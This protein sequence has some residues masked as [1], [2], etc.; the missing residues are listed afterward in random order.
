MRDDYSKRT[1]RQYS[2]RTSQAVTRKEY[3]NKPKGKLL[4]VKQGYNPNSSSMGSI[5]F[6]LPVALLGI[7]AVFG[8]VS[9]I[10]MSWHMKNGVKGRSGKDNP[11]DKDD[12]T[13]EKTK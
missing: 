8:A 7:T 4:R 12:F 10:I 13:D 6:V 11:S 1:G 2:C 5:V 9:G 3:N